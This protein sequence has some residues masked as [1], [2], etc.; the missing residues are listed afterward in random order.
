M[1]ITYAKE[2]KEIPFKDLKVGELYC[3]SEGVL[4]LKINETP[5]YNIIVVDEMLLAW[6]DENNIIIPLDAELIIK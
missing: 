6:E 2:K 4:C 3:D 5:N 1:K